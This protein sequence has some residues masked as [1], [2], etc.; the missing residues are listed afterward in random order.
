MTQRKVFY[1]IEKP[2]RLDYIV[3]VQAD[4]T[5]GSNLAGCMYPDCTGNGEREEEVFGC[6]VCGGW[7]CYSHIGY[8]SACYCCQALSPAIQT[9]V[10]AFREKLNALR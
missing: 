6:E 8:N 9:E 7:Y 4:E 5:T 10:K 3:A 2:V 1:E